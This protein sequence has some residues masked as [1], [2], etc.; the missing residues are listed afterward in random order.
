[1]YLK[2]KRGH[3]F[4]SVLLHPFKVGN[5]LKITKQPSP[6]V[7]HRSAPLNLVKPQFCTRV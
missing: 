7:Q 5:R 2:I 6:N 4:E 3:H 1:V